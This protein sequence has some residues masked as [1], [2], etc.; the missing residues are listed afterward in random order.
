MTLESNVYWALVIILGCNTVVCLGVTWI[1]RRKRETWSLEDTLFC[2]SL[3]LT[4]TVMIFF[5]SVEEWAE[6]RSRDRDA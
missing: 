2:L 3:I 4:G 6:G 1:A 5:P